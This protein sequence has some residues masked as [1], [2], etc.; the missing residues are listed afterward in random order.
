VD[1]PRLN[2]MTDEQRVIHVAEQLARNN[3]IHTADTE[4]VRDYLFSRK[5]HENTLTDYFFEKD[6]PTFEGNVCLFKASELS[7]ESKKVADDYGW[8][9]FLQGNFQTISVD[10]NHESLVIAPQV[11]SL[12]VALRQF[13][14]SV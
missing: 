3:I 5:Q 7:S 11:N 13:I 10:G 2:E 1:L 9:E 4:F 12:G 8:S 14:E 6:F